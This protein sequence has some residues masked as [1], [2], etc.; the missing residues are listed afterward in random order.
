MNPMEN[1]DVE[2]LKQL[3]ETLGLVL[4]DDGYAA[5]SE[6]TQLTVKGSHNL[7]QEGNSPE[8]H[9]KNLEELFNAVCF[10]LAD[11]EFDELSET[12]QVTTKAAF[13][14]YRNRYPIDGGLSAEEFL[15]KKI[16]DAF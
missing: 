3:D 16:A 11:D 7:Y 14:L 10:V 12:A 8:E 4:G 13:D 2:V 9:C 15:E 1:L 5:L 6:F